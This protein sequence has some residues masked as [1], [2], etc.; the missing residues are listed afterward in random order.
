M[1]ATYPAA[2]DDPAVPMGAIYAEYPPMS[3]VVFPSGCEGW[4]VTRYEDVRKVFSDTRFSRDLLGPGAP[5]MIEPGDFST[6][7]H[8]ILN[9]D[10]PDH[11]RLRKLSAQAFTVRRIAA[12]RPRIEELAASLLRSRR[13]S[14]RR[15][16]SRRPGATEP[17][18]W[19]HSSPS[20][21]RVRAKTC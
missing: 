10:P 1:T 5:C 7:E 16:R 19:R 9:M 2:K 20:N 6:G 4:L 18:T 11:T 21:G 12:L 8:S 15:T 14:T 17:T 13:F 3:R